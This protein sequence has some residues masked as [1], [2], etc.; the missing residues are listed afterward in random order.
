MANVVQTKH[1]A[2]LE[3]DQHAGV[4]SSMYHK[5]IVQPLYELLEPALAKVQQAVTDLTS[6]Q[7]NLQSASADLEQLLQ[8]R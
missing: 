5:E 6:G 1:L 7:R 8:L 4:G 2:Y 3:P